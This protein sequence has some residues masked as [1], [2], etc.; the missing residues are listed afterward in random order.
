MK[1]SDWREVAA[2]VAWGVLGGV[3]WLLGVVAWTHPEVG[4]GLGI[5]GVCFGLMAL[6]TIEDGYTWR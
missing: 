5:G 1:P 2:G 4:V 3:V 6:A